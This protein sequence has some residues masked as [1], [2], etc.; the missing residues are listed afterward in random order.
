MN[1]FV[2]LAVTSVTIICGGPAAAKDKT[3]PKPPELY[4]KLAACRSVSDAA[5]RLA[6]YDDAA[7]KLDAA[8]AS[9]DVVVVDKAQVRESRKTLFGLS[10][11]S[12][13]LFGGDDDEKD[14]I[15]TI[16]SKV[17]SVWRVD[18]FNIGVKLEDGARWVQVDGKSIRDPKPG[19][20]IKIRKASMGS[21]LANIDDGPAIRMERRN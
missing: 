18:K 17:A 21:F 5:A 15:T 10:L 6:C 4:G 13:K 20:M 16:E 3:P 2:L 11:P 1:K 9:S 19:Q 7:A 12:F 14:Q 8:I